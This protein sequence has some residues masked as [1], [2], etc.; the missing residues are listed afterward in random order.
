MSINPYAS[1]STMENPNEV[2]YE[3][4]DW[5]PLLLEHKWPC[6]RKRCDNLAQVRVTVGRVDRKYG[7]C[8]DLC[9]ECQDD[10]IEIHFQL[11]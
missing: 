11:K 1:Q 7:E 2:E 10:A 3:V 4:K 9:L 5:K 6:E 8:Y